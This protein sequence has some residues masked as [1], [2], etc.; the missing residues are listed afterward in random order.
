MNE[1]LRVSETVHVTGFDGTVPSAPLKNC[2]P[3][4]D[5]LTNDRTSRF[6]N[7]DVFEKQLKQPR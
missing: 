6:G 5:R 4:K 3:K 7:F 2:W 1:V